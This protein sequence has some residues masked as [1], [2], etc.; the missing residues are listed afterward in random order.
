MWETPSLFDLEKRMKTA[1]EKRVKLLK[2]D[3]AVKQNIDR[4]KEAEH[5]CRIIAFQ[6]KNKCTNNG[7]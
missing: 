6:V 5:D 3:C 2:Q 4:M 7:N 1:D